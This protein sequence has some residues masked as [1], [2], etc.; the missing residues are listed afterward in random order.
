LLVGVSLANEQSFESQ[1][2]QY[3]FQ[4]A[5]NDDGAHQRQESGQG[6][7]VTGVFSY[8]DPNGHLRQVR[9][10]ANEHGF[11]PEG[12]ISVDKETAA[13]GKPFFD[14]LRYL[15]CTKLICSSIRLSTA[16][17]LAQVANQAAAEHHLLS[18]PAP[19]PINS[20]SQPQSVAAFTNPAA[21]TSQTFARPSSSYQVLSSASTASSTRHQAT[22][23]S[24]Q[25]RPAV[26]RSTAAASKD[27]LSSGSFGAS[28]SARF[29][30]PVSS[31]AAAPISP[32]TQPQYSF[33]SQV[34]HAPSQLEAAS[35]E[36]N[37]NPN[38]PSTS[39]SATSGSQSNSEFAS[40]PSVTTFVQPKLVHRSPVS[41]RQRK[42]SN[43]A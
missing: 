39:Y 40:S 1:P 36:S 38:K 25:A 32:S 41:Y 19:Y 11:Y 20:F 30:R 4:Y 17:S 42:R 27:Q 43:Q 37:V 14:S 28:N 15:P 34:D 33:S 2:L 7:S 26:H 9:Y 16:E 13:Q 6:K 21:S 31:A 24:R 22:T 29:N 5:N 12:D 23:F 10:L 35:F 3:S 18:A 8:I